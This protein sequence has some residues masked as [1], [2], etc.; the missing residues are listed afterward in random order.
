MIQPGVIAILVSFSN[1]IELTK[2][3][4]TLFDIKDSLIWLYV[5]APVINWI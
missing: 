4:N 5:S 3:D 2:C 1:E